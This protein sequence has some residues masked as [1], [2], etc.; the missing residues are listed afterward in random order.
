[1]QTRYLY[2]LRFILLIADLA[3]LNLAFLASFYLINH[4]DNKLSLSLYEHYLFVCN[5]IWLFSAY[6]LGLYSENTIQ[7]VE[8]IYRGTWRSILVHAVLFLTFLVFSKDTGLS[9]SF[10]LLFYGILAGGFI[11]SRFIGTIVETVLRKHFKIRKPVAVLGHNKAGMRLAAFFEENKNN[12]QFNGFLNE[13]DRAYVDEN[14]QLLP[15]AREQIQTAAVRGVK[16]VYVS[17]T[18]ARMSEVGHLVQ[19]AERQ[20][21]RL[22]FVPD[23][24]SGIAAPF[25][26]NY[27]GEFPVI[28]IRKE[29]LEDIENRFKK[30]FFDIAFSLLVIIGILSWLYPILAVIIKLQSPGPVLFKQL[31]SGRDNQPFWCYKFRSMRMNNDSET[32]Q[33]SKDDDRIT[34]V[35]K[36]LRKT[37][38][39]ELPQFFNVL[40]GNMSVIGPRPHMLSHTEQYRKL[41]DQYMVRQ[42]LKP[43]ISGW[44]QVHGYRGETKDSSLME[45]RVEH[46]IWYMEN[47][48][49]MLDIKIIFMTIINAVKGEENAF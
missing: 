15:S 14:G 25:Q 41:I 28:S 46:D 7:K 35:G 44:A 38:L 43:G 33:A 29:P 48:S 36:F 4:F 40:I 27:M 21:V 9:R 10:F 3:L 22:K 42:F 17:L 19:E 47:W 2:L 18:P 45:K 32:R 26:M 13:E 16:E 8:L 24:S 39:D 34:P 31:R 30:R 6:M 1:M 49:T 5:L 23:L 37:S 20:C 12:F 11:L